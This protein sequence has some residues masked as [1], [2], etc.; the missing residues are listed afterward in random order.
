M[1]IGVSLPSTVIGG[2][3]GAQIAFAQ[4]A[5][6]LGYDHLALYEHVVGINPATRPDW[7]GP[8]T[9]ESCFHDPFVL[10]GFL[11]AHTKDIILTTH[12]LILAQRQT[13]LVARQA[14]SVDLLSGGRLRLGVGIGWN[15][16]EFT[17][18]GEDF[19]TR[20][21]RSLEQ[22]EVLQALWRDE[23]VEYQGQWHTLPNVGLN[24]RPVQRP[25]PIW[26]GGHHDN[27]LRR[28]ASHGDG[29]VIL[30]YLPDEKG[31]AEIAKLRGMIAEAGRSADAV[32]L[33]AWVS[34]GGTAPEDWRAEVEG[35]RA[36]GVTYLTVNTAFGRMHHTPIAEDTLDAHIDA[37]RRYREA[38]ADLLEGA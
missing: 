29:W 6:E 19:S 1:K 18:L 26:L 21:K 38:V 35:W 33:D 27:V 12:V 15:P 22:I 32:G 28:I 30:A 31:A 3:P 14:A 7:K 5:E 16:V 11:A 25:I 13:V 37:V 23:H 34:M 17:V 8:Y 2:D 36:L 20:G 4:A 9:S 10:M 24:P